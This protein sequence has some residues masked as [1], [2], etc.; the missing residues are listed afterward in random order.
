MNYVPLLIVWGLLAASTMVLIVWRLFVASGEDDA[1]HLADGE[2]AMLR[3]QTVVAEK[4]ELIDKWGKALTAMTVL[5][6][7]TIAGIYLYHLWVTTST[8]I[9]E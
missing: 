2:Q 8:I 4:L 7:L 6:G 1:L 5:L 3:Q 9:P